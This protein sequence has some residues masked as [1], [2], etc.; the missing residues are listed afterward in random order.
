MST[1]KLIS[2]SVLGVLLAGASINS[3]ASI[4][5]FHFAYKT[6]DAIES[7][8]TLSADDAGQAAGAW[9]ITSLTGKRNGAAMTLLPQGTFEANDNLMF[10]PAFKPDF[11]G[12]SFST[13]DGNFNIYN[14]GNAS[15]RVRECRNACVSGSEFNLFSFSVTPVPEPS[16]TFLTLAGLIGIA[17]ALRVRNH[18]SQ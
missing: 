15:Q 17:T 14:S 4:Q 9:Q 12:W 10:A 7:F 1:Q 8:G 11:S 16:T 3:A 5:I 6:S 2:A 13:V 18:R